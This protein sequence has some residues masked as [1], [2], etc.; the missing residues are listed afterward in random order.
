MTVEVRQLPEIE[1][2]PKVGSSIISTGNFLRWNRIRTYTS[3]LEE[4]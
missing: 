4:V 1:V 3:N 2:I